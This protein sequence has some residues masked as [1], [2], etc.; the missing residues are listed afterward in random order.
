MG[1]I[2]DQPVYTSIDGGPRFELSVLEVRSCHGYAEHPT[3]KPIGILTPLISYSCP[4][5]GLVLDPTAGAGSTLVAAK[6][7]GRR[8]I[9]IELDEKFCEVAARRVSQEMPL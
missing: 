5:G 9:G 6:R 2:G 3:Q 8:S 1:E 4:P 7:S